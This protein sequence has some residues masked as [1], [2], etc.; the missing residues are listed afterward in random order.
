M[1]NTKIE[2]ELDMTFVE[3][4]NANHDRMERIKKAKDYSNHCTRQKCK[5]VVLG[6]LVVAFFCFALYIS[7]KM[8]MET[9]L[10]QEAIETGTR[11]MSAVLVDINEETGDY[12]LQTEDGHL[13]SISD[14]PE[15][16]YSVTFDTNG[17][18]DVTDDKIVGLE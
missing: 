2:K 13:W 15:V 11:T 7:G 18:I 14:A 17:T 16:V 9:I 3:M 1:N 12:V 5:H 8:D 4:V 6:F 10:A